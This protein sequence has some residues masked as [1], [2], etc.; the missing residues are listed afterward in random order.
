MKTARRIL[1]DIRY[2]M[3]PD[4]FK[5][6]STDDIRKHFLVERLFEEDRATMVYSHIDR[7]IVGGIFPVRQAVPLQA[8]KALGVDYLLQRREMGIINIASQGVVTV[9]GKEYV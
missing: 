9:D 1:M 8:T 3:H 7:I 2:A 4:Q 6:L 5:S